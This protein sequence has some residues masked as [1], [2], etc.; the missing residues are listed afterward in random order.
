MNFPEQYMTRA[1]R[2]AERGLWS[3]DPNPRVGCVLVRDNEIVGESWH[4]RAGEPH[5]EIL[6]LQMAG[7]RARGADC[8]VSL[9][10]CCHHG[11]TPP[12]TDALIAAGIKRVIA[13]MID[14]NPQ[15]AGKGLQQ[16]QA[17]GIEIQSGVLAEQ[18]AQLNPGFIKRMSEGRPFVRC[19]LAMSL[20]GR[21]AMAS[22]ESQW[23]TSTDARRD[24]QA[25]RARSSA[26]MTGI[27]TVLTDDPAFTVREAELS[28]YLPRPPFICTPLRVI[29]DRNLSTPLS[30]KLLNSPGKT[31]IFTST[32][33]T[34]M[35]ESL[36]ERGAEV[37]YLP[38]REGCI[39]LAVVLRELANREI[40]EVLLE[41]GANLSG[42][43]LQA[44]LIDEI[45][46]YMAPT[47]LGNAARGLFHLPRLERLDQQIRLNIQEIRAVGVDWRIRAVPVLNTK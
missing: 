28:P 16:L 44:G 42:S 2:L 46:I 11:K 39:D 3:T 8:Y 5:A 33:D 4:Q 18:A 27:V 38:T 30:A 31:L 22:G 6:A 41:S 10:P 15:V 34:E 12:C 9:E 21:T 40:N 32:Q 36:E 25:L 45:V 1:L 43:M 23:I 29:I 7:E 35:Q 47:L 24:V 13:A 14:P 19:K 17:A 26:I 20:D 37:I